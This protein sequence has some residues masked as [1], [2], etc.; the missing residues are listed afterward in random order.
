MLPVDIQ[1]QVERDMN[2]AQMGAIDPRTLLESLNHPKV[3][4]IMKRIK[5]MQQQLVCSLSGFTR[6]QQLGQLLRPII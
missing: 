1:S 3:D 5:E 2:L 6:Q 4:V